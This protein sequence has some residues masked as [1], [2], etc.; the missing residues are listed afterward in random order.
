MIEELADLEMKEKWA[1]LDE[2]IK[3]LMSIASK[4]KMKRGRYVI[5]FIDIHESSL[6]I[7]GSCVY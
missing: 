7:C 2:R 5:Y 1:L 6:L 4:L 3:D